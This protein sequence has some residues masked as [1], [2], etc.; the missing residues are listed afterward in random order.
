[1][2]IPSFFRVIIQEYPDIHFWDKNLPIDHLFFDFNCLIYECVQ[3]LQRIPLDTFDS[4]DKQLLDTICKYTQ[5]I[6][7]DIVKPSKSVY[8]AV[9]GPAPVAKMI[10]QRSRRYKRML[11]DQY[12]E[13]LH[14][15]YKQK[16]SYNFKF[17]TT[18]LSP[19]TEFMTQMSERLREFAASGG[20]CRHLRSVEARTGFSVI[21]SDSNLPGEGEH[22]IMKRI[23]S[24]RRSKETINDR[25]SIYGLDA[26]LIVLSIASR[27]NNIYILREPRYSDVE[28]E[29]YSDTEFLYINIDKCKNGFLQQYLPNAKVDS[30]YRLLDDL[31][32]LTFLCGNDFVR[33]PPFL[34]VKSGGM[35]TIMNL[36]KRSRRNSQD[37]LVDKCSAQINVRL[38][39]R[40]FNEL[41][42]MEKVELQKLDERIQTFLTKKTV[43]VSMDTVRDRERGMTPLKIHLARWQHEE[44]FS[45]WYPE[46]ENDGSREYF[47]EFR[48]SDPEKW[49]SW[50]FHVPKVTEDIITDYLE[51][52]AFTFIYYYE[53][54]AGISWHY[55]Y[56][57]HVPPLPSDVYKYL[58]EKYDGEEKYETNGK[59]SMREFLK[60]NINNNNKEPLTPYQQLC[61]IFPPPKLRELLPIEFAESV[62]KNTPKEWY[63]EPDINS[64]ETKLCRASG[65]K[66]IY[67]EPELKKI[68]LEHLLKVTTAA[69]EGNAMKKRDKIRNRIKRN[70]SK[71][72]F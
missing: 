27:K 20:F 4:P 10:Q 47:T 13:P 66:W 1:M 64:T 53:G 52:L 37:W 45:P 11:E 32:F 33:A 46:R 38:L 61:M 54:I 57:P 68:P 55:A 34:L 60:F 63:P 15:M 42:Q 26:D 25:V 48:Y 67:C 51:S 35:D 70:A 43:T 71:F 31:V 5:H 36:Y 62:L 23:K 7:C 65:M 8:I 30:A 22:K 50:L 24:F 72:I 49:Y 17:D 58:V 14:T 28:Q 39:I 9:D 21:I 69:M 59:I 41:S 16:R 40:I 56:Y 3:Q 29:F 19:G 6:I 2:G 44:F 18:R 12:K